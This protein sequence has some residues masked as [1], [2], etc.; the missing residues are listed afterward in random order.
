MTTETINP[1]RLP[2][3]EA[4]VPKDNVA[5]A[6]HSLNSNETCYVCNMPMTRLTIGERH[7]NIPAFVCVK[8]RIALPIKD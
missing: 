6:A 7:R 4:A 2:K 1:L 5:L 3:T 8:D